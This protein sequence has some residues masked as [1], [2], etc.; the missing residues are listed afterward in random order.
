MKTRIIQDEPEP[1]Q[2]DASAGARRSPRRLLPTNLPA[3]IGSL[4]RPAPQ[5]GDL[6]LARVRRSSRS[7]SATWS[8]RRTSPTSTV[9]RRVPRCREGARR[10]R[11]AA[12]RGGR[13]SSRATSSPSSDPAFRAAVEDVTGR[14]SRSPVRREH[15]VAARTAA[16][17]S[18]DGHAAL[19]N[20]EIAGDSTEAADRVD[21]TLAAV[22]RGP[23]R[24]SRPRRRAVRRRQRRQGDR[25]R[26][27]PTTSRKAGRALAADHADHPHD[28]LRLA[29]G[30]GRAAADRAHLRDGRA[31][32]GRA[33]R[34]SCSRS[35]ATSPRWSC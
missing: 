7:W 18:A 9:H 10:R 28:H 12:D 1:E 15:E 14:L 8:A 3:R 19:V 34:A 6:R 4:E 17:V 31:R 20:F 22:G 11:P 35:T 27:S 30:G 24:A 29:R 13:A 23:G 33:S 25:R 21:P 16:P 2:P 5:E 32:P 26:R